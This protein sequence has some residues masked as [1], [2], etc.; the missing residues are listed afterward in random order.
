MKT[1]EAFKQALDLLWDGKH[2]EDGHPHPKGKQRFGCL[3][4]W[5]T[6]RNDDLAAPYEK[7][8]TDLLAPHRTLEDWLVKQGHMRDEDN[9]LELEFNTPLMQ[10]VQATRKAWLEHLIEHYKSIGD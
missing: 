7:I 10:K 2:M 5:C 4:V 3:A 6:T 9:N 8:L 1:S